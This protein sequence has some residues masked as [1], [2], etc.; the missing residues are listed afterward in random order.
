MLLLGLHQKLPA[1]SHSP[2]E[3]PHGSKQ[4]AENQALPWERLASPPG[5]NEPAPGSLGTPAGK[6]TEQEERDA[7]SAKDAIAPGA[8]LVA[9]PAA[10]VAPAPHPG[11]SPV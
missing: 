6:V 9:D 11:M 2:A 10:E 7:A 3:R 8:L 1:P 4:R 5:G